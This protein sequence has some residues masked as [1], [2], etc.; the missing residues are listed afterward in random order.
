M[1]MVWMPDTLAANHRFSVELME[2]LHGYQV[3]H[4]GY[5]HKRVEAQPT[6]PMRNKQI[7]DAVCHGILSGYTKVAKLA[8]FRKMK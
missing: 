5:D 7:K 1:L 4:T 6:H 2:N 3:K 8:I